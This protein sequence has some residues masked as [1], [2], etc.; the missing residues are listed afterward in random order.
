MVQC[1]LANIFPFW[2]SFRGRVV[3]ICA[4]FPLFLCVW[5]VINKNWTTTANGRPP[6]DASCRPWRHPTSAVGIDKQ[7]MSDSCTQVRMNCWISLK[8]PH[9]KQPE[10]IH[11]FRV[12]I[13]WVGV[14]T[15]ITIVIVFFGLN[16]VCFVPLSQLKFHVVGIAKNIFLDPQ[17][18]T[19]Q[20]FL[21]AQNMFARIGKG[22]SGAVV[23]GGNAA[24]VG[25]RLVRRTP[26]ISHTTVRLLKAILTFMMRSR[27]HCL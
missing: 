14:G 17:Q 20:F 12:A 7:G 4:E 11:Y 24:F 23:L 26:L 3:F 9:K 15:R 13:V 21:A 19:T 5:L 10:S 22:L 1:S 25:N 18:I 16:S 2:G 8:F 6:C 27:L